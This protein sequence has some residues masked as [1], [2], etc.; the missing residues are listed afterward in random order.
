MTPRD[1]DQAYDNMSH[2]AGSAALPAHWAAEAA[3]YRA[4]GVSV[5]ED[6]P[7]GAG[8]RQ[9]LDIVWPEGTP[10]GLAVFVHGG[11]WMRLYK[12]DWTQF[13]EGARARGWAVAIPG[14]TLAP[15]AR[16]AQITCEIR[17][18]VDCA[19]GR[20]AG[21]IRLAGHSAG[22]H[23][24]SRLVC[25]DV[26]PDCADRIDHV[27]SVSGLHDLR[28]LR[29]TRMNDTLRLDAAEAR[30]ESPALCTP[31]P[32]TRLTAWAGGGERPEFIRQAQALDQIWGGFDTR[33]RAHVDGLHHHFSVIEGLKD[34]AS[35]ITQAFVGTAP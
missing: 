15:E 16:I 2:V 19:A 27:L 20:V 11:Y 8:E 12:S 22:G 29:R 4:G 21:P 14:Y 6:I 5:E 34:P 25:E 28:P 24:V 31:R 18:A 3:A 1:W 30:A 23:L 35:Q 32:G 7:Y 33:T 10:R 17:D 9:K 26:T 13:A